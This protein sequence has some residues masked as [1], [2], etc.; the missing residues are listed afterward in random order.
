MNIRKALRHIRTLNNFGCHCSSAT[1]TVP[2]PTRQA[3]VEFVRLYGHTRNQFIKSDAGDFYIIEVGPHIKLWSDVELDLGESYR[4]SVVLNDAESAICLAAAFFPADAF[5]ADDSV[6]FSII[7]QDL[8][9]EKAVD[10]ATELGGPVEK[11]EW[12]GSKWLRCDDITA[13]FLKETAS[14]ED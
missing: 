11:I 6:S 8:T 12:N 10:V 9:V 2:R 4:E 14:V 5:S 3:I 13:L 1:I 7:G